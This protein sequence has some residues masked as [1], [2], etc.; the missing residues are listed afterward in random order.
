MGISAR[1]H[2]KTKWSLNELSAVNGADQFYN[3][4]R[5]HSA[6]GYMTPTQYEMGENVA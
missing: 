1:W 4:N 3:R 5:L 6:L 2:L